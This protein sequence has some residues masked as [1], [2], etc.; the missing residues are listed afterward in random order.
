MQTR[1]DPKPQ[2]LVVRFAPALYRRMRALADARR[3]SL[4]TLVVVAM[5]DYIDRASREEET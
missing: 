1:S 4:N 3:W 2:R 5:E